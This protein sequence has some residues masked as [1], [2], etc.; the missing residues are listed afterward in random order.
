MLK[1]E[2]TTLQNKKQYEFD[3]IYLLIYIFIIIINL[4]IKR[5]TDIL[6][7]PEIVEMDKQILYR[8]RYHHSFCLL[9]QVKAKLSKVKPGCGII[10]HKTPD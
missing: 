8:K 10:I 3:H 5:Y 6:L 7:D 4:D 1:S 9:P 2:Q